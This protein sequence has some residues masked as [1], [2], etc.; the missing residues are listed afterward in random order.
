MK[1][2][3]LAL[4][5]GLSLNHGLVA[6]HADAIQLEE[7]IKTTTSWDGEDLPDYGT[8]EAQ[9]TILKATIPPGAQF[10]LHKH[11]VI[12]AGVL[13]TGQL[14]VVTEE[15]D[16][17]RVTAGEA[18]VEVVGEWHFGINDGETPAEII[19]FYAGHADQPITVSAER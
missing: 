1:A 9:I 6:Q 19:V 14:M 11:P 17:L 13:T 2:L 8:G 12:N 3:L 15:S 16:T 7:L 18:L 10:P 5:L 4:A